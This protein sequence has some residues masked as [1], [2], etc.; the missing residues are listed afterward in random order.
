M[1]RGF[2]TAA[3]GMIAQ[4][5]R[6]EMLTNNIANAD[7]PGFKEDTASLRAFPNM[8]IKAIGVDNR[9][10]GKSQN[11]GELTTG[12]YLQERTL[13]FRQGDMQ[14]TNNNT[15]IA[16]LQGNVPINEATGKPGALFFTVENEIGETR[17]SRN[18]NF[19]IDGNGFLTTGEGFYAL[20]NT[21][22]R[23]NVGNED[24]NMTREGL[25]T[26]Q[27]G[28]AV[29]QLNVVLVADPNQLV[30]EG[31]GLLRYEGALPV[32]TAIGNDNV[33]YQLQQGFIERSNVD[34][35]QSMTDMMTAFRA[36]E[37]NQK[38]LQA[39]DRSMEKAV[40]EIGR[41]G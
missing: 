16:L 15:D 29:T 6:Q 38:V 4:Q 19:T 30:K 20:D 25:I 32:V 3:S 24:F 12:A 27:E 33:T 41:L 17:Y 40:N 21:G 36:F 23:I 1:I 5:R 26:N 13:N 10:F 18:G 7:T 11:V 2:Y 31:N 14:E 34:T 9:P 8:L 39:Y 22:E 35:A 37:A 28:V